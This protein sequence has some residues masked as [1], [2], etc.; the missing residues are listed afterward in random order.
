MRKRNSPSDV[1]TTSLDA[2][3]SRRNPLPGF[4]GSDGRGPQSTAPSPQPVLHHRG[5]HPPGHFLRGEPHEPL[6]VR[7]VPRRLKDHGVGPGVGQPVDRL[8]DGTGVP[9]HSEIGFGADALGDQLGAEPLVGAGSGGGEEID[10]DC[11]RRSLTPGRRTPLLDET[12]GTPNTL[13]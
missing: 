9:G 8:G 3:R 10:D 11:V 5:P 12:P 13:G 2:H 1:R 6:G 7:L 4:P